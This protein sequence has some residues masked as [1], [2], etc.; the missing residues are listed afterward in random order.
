MNEAQELWWEQAKSDYAAFELLR[1]AGVH[2]CHPLH[3]LQMAAE[4]LSKA[5]L[6]RIGT[7]PPRSHVGLMRF[8]Q[9]LLSRGHGRRELDRIAQIFEYARH[10]DMTAW[11]RQVAPL[12]HQLQNLTPD[13]AH[14]GPNPE[15]PWPHENPEHCPARHS[16]DLWRK[17]RDTELGRRLV[18]FIK[19][20]IERFEQ[21]A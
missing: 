18:K 21:F 17:L 9:A 11:V 20:A 16:F 6:W 13:L 12:A 19:R 15:Y 1:G 7:A 8:L 14:D 10:E 2:E 4:K 5:Y 3:Y